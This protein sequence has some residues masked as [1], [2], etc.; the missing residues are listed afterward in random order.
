MHAQ[1]PQTDEWKSGLDALHDSL[2]LEHQISRHLLD[3]HW[4]AQVKNDAN[5]SNLT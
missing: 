5:V 2:K 3:L 4:D 1:K